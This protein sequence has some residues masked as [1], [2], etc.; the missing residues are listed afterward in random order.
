MI[1]IIGNNGCA[2]C[3]NVKQILKNNNINFEYMLL[4][5]INVRERVKYIQMAHKA[6]QLEL[7]L[8]IKDNQ[9]VKLEEILEN[10]N[11]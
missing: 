2:K 10:N 5:E 1:K 9:I 6:K 3:N 4:D 8:I 7:P 11:G